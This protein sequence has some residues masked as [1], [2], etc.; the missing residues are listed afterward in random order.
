MD[1]WSK[2]T[3][4]G[5]NGSIKP[6]GCFINTVSCNVPWRTAFKTSSCKI[7]HLKVTATL[8]RTRIVGSL[9]YWKETV[10]CW[11]DEHLYDKDVAKI[12]EVSWTQT[13]VHEQFW[14]YADVCIQ[15]HRSVQAYTNKYANEEYQIGR[16][17]VE[18]V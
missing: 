1:F 13:K 6:G 12:F 18:I 16:E 17:V 8:R 5:Y 7:C 2:Q 4:S 14:E 11:L 15:Q 10:E 9:A 3:W